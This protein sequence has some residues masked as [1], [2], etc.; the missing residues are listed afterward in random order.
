LRLTEFIEDEFLCDERFRGSGL[1]NCFPLFA[2]SLSEEVG[3]V[4]NVGSSDDVSLVSLRLKPFL[5]RVGRVDGLK[6]ESS[7]RTDRLEDDISLLGGDLAVSLV[8]DDESRNVLNDG[9]DRLNVTLSIF[10]NDSDF[11][12]SNSESP[13]SFAVT[14]DETSESGLNLLEVEAKTVKEIELNVMKKRERSSQLRE[15]KM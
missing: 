1:S 11:G 3:E 5:R 14:I 8:F 7:L 6:V 12:T 10:E 15:A 9:S 4:V 13:E 2:N